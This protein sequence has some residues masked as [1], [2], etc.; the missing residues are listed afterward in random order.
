M[1]YQ[2]F[3]ISRFN[4]ILGKRADQKQLN[5]KPY[6][7]F[8]ARVTQRRNTTCDTTTLGLKQQQLQIGLRKV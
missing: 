7:F 2:N 4:F 5:I 8:I 3:T 1:A 6:P